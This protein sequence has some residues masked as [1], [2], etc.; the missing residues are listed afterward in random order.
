MGIFSFLSSYSL[1]EDGIYLYNYSG[2]SKYGTPV[3]IGMIFYFF[4]NKVL[5]IE[6]T[7]KYLIGKEEVARI[8]EGVKIFEENQMNLGTY[9]LNNSRIKISF[10]TNEYI[11]EIKSNSMVLD[12]YAKVF[13]FSTYRDEREK[14]LS[15]TVFNFIQK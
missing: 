7:G 2:L 13:N 12:I 5:R 14:L 10:P 4:D 11:G 15:S 1:R 6:Q 3:E 9:E 8:M